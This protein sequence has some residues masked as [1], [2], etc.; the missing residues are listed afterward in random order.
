MSAGAIGEI[1][2][3]GAVLGDVAMFS[4]VLSKCVGKSKQGVGW[5]SE[6]DSLESQSP[7]MW[8]CR[9]RNALP[10]GCTSNQGLWVGGGVGVGPH[11]HHCLTEKQ[12][13][14]VVVPFRWMHTAVR[15][16]AL[17]HSSTP[18]IFSTSH[19]GCW[20]AASWW[21]RRGIRFLIVHRPSGTSCVRWLYAS[22]DQFPCK[23]PTHWSPDPGE[24]NFLHSHSYP[25]Y[26][27]QIKFCY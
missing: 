8:P 23:V 9:Y 16:D 1:T 7:S 10:L 17:W 3:V 4:G 5:C 21:Q 14:P 2:V 26:I 11:L 22:N 15:W 25:L 20:T 18:V 24:I 13:R 6:R 19:T 27:R 12:A